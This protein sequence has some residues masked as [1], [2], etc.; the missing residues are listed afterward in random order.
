M[1]QMLTSEAPQRLVISFTQTRFQ[2]KNLY[3][4]KWV[5][6]D[7]KDFATKAHMLGLPAFVKAPALVGNRVNLIQHNQGHLGA[8][9]QSDQRCQFSR[10]FLKEHDSDCLEKEGKSINLS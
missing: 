2:D 4:Q 6:C 9:P 3:T 10:F 1:K 7:K 5:N 8:N